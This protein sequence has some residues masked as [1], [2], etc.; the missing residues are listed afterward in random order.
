[1]NRKRLTFIFALFA[2]LTAGVSA[3]EV[4]SLKG[5]ALMS[6][7]QSGLSPVLDDPI[8]LNATGPD[9]E[10]L[11]AALIEGSTVTELIEANEGDVETVIAAL[12]AQSRFR[13]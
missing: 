10:A 12:V 1:M 5:H 7:G 2:L 4:P 11:G 3:H 8:V 6:Y 9:A 13:D